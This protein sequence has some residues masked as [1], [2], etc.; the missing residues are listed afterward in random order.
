MDST[1]VD[2]QLGTTE[3]IA[4]MPHDLP[5][6]ARAVWVALAE[7][8]NGPHLARRIALHAG[9]SEP[10]A[11]WTLRALVRVGV[12]VA[13]GRRDRYQPQGLR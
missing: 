1:R 4:E 11:E 7:W 9:L 6:D 3:W 2:R 10:A 8:P 12:L 13:D 5:P